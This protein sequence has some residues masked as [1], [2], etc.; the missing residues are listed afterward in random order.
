MNGRVLIPLLSSGRVLTPTLVG[1]ISLAS[2]RSG[3][4]MPPN[5]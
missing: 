4:N 1:I 3:H 2:L 5:F